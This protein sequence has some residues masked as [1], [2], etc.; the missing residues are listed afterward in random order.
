MAMTITEQLEL[1]DV[2]SVLMDM[3][4]VLVHEQS[5]RSPVRPRC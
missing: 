5:S 3:D 4:G 2:E 1:D